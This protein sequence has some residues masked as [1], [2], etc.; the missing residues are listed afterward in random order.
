[1]AQNAHGKYSALSGTFIPQPI[2]TTADQLTIVASSAANVVVSA[3]A[4][5]QFASASLARNI[6][7]VVINGVTYYVPCSTSTW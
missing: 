3:T 5:I 7:T 1:M 2:E 6:I 4:G